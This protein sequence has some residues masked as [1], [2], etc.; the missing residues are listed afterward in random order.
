MAENHRKIIRAFGDP[1]FYPHK[2]L[3]LDHL[4]THLSH[5]F[6][7]GGLVYKIKKPLDLGF[8][9]FSTLEN[10][11]HFCLKEVE[12]NRRLAPE[13]YLQ[14]MAVAKSENGLSLLP[15]EKV[16]RQDVLEPCV[17]MREMDQSRLMDRLLEADQVTEQDI[18]S[19]G[20]KTARF[21]SS[22]GQS[23]K[24]DFFG[25][26][27]Q[28]RINVEENFRQTEPH[29]GVT[30]S[31]P[32]WQ[33]VK[34]YSY[35]FMEQNQDLFKQ[36]VD[37]GHIVDGH[38][39][40]HSGNIVLPP[41]RDP[42]IFDCIEFNERFRYQ[43]AACDLAFLAMDLDFHQKANLTRLLLKHY[44][45]TGGDRD[46]LKIINFYMCYRAVVRAK[47]H[48]FTFEDQEVPP[49]QKFTDLAK[50]RAYFRLAAQYAQNEPPYFL[51]CFMG[52]MASGKSYMA[53]L[54]AGHLGWP[55][56]NSDRM[57]KK[58]A[59]IAVDERHYDNW[60]RG[61][62]DPLATE[63]TYQALAH[64]AEPHLAMGQS[65]ILDASFSRAGHRETMLELA[66]KTGATPLFV[67]VWA[68]RPVL[69]KRLAKRQA[70]A[71]TVS[72]GRLE[73]LDRQISSFEKTSH[74]LEQNLFKLDG[75]MPEQEKLNRML[76]KLTEMG[77]GR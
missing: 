20:Q 12:L 25:R 74:L 33:A 36:R 69:E 61:L 60:G 59:G 16:D 52:L 27:E 4:Q 31:R 68:R 10:R 50:A 5:I 66:R 40:L 13:I 22:Q 38:G 49:E 54:L 24:V 48:G 47:I 32:R 30:A 21:H 42:I 6:L 67:E 35:G 43:D 51:V 29:L 17:Q 18:I 65:V 57:R 76:D 71:R 73:L 62:Y 58:T 63:K 75:G 1:A 70:K 28:V 46:L 7:T 53:K 3:Q 45:R 39:D 37:K 8:V 19:L 44:V 14:V 72:D 41:D 23:S 15:L 56:E 64:W 26:L 11:I 9:D 2:V 55:H 77:H 34:D